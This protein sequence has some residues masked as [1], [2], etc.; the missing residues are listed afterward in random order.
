MLFDSLPEFVLFLLL[1]TLFSFSVA[2]FGFFFHPLKPIFAGP[3][4]PFAIE[5]YKLVKPF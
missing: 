1:N 4:S 2:A 3:L 5:G